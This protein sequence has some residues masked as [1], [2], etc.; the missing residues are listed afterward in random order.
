[1]NCWR[2]LNYAY[3]PQAADVPPFPS[4]SN[5][6]SARRRQLV[7]A[8][9][10]FLGLRAPTEA[11]LADRTGVEEGTRWSLVKGRIDFSGRRGTTAEAQA[12]WTLS[13]VN[14]I[15]NSRKF[16]RFCCQ[17]RPKQ[18]YGKPLLKAWADPVE[19][20]GINQIESTSIEYDR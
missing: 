8:Q 16:H 11:R 6:N 20:L 7:L 14:E 12:R 19:Q 9:F 13:T 5:P 18:L 15:G 1:M 4:S 2:K 17:P 10:A 3:G